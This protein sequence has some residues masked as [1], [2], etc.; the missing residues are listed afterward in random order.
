M[1]NEPTCWLTFARVAWP[2]TGACAIEKKR[3]IGRGRGAWRGDAKDKG[4]RRREER[5][6]RVGSGGR[7]LED[8]GKYQWRGDGNGERRPLSFYL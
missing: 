5:V 1:E 4:G 6:Y 7:E 8:G 3:G 2:L